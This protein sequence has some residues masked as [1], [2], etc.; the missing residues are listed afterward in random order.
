MDTEWAVVLAVA[1]VTG[2]FVLYF[3]LPFGEALAGFLAFA[4]I[5]AACCRRPVW[6]FALAVLAQGTKQTAASSLLVLGLVCARTAA[7]RSSLPRAYSCLSS[8]VCSRPYQ[9]TPHS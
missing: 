8:E 7:D 2:P 6:I 1:I 4:F 5:M 9:A 3:L